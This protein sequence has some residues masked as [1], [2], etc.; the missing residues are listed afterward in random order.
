MVSLAG[1]VAGDGGPALIRL[2]CVDELLLR[3]SFRPSIELL[4]P[5]RAG[6]R[7]VAAPSLQA[8]LRA[9]ENFE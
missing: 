3:A 4:N 9:H 1:D 8:A 5:S 2:C 7:T 6:Y